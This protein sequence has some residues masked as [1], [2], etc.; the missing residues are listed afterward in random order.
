[1]RLAQTKPAS[2]CRRAFTLVEML[3]VIV[4]II[5]L[6][7]L[8]ATGYY[9]FIGGQQ[10]RNTEGNIRTINKIFQEQ[11]TFVVEQAKKET[12]SPATRT[13]ANFD[14]G[15]NN[16]DPTGERARV[17]WIK[18]R[19]VE[20]FPMTYDEIN[21][22]ADPVYLILSNYIPTAQRKNWQNY[23]RATGGQ[24]SS[25]K[26]T[27]SESSACLLMALSVSRGGSV[28]SP[29]QLAS[30]AI[31]TDGDGVKE[32]VD[33]WRTPLAFYRFAW[34][35]SPLLPNAP[36]GIQGLNPAAAGAKTAKLADPLDPS[37][38]LLTWP[39]SP[40]RVGFE[41]YLHRIATPSNNANANYVIP[42]IASAGLDQGLVLTAPTQ[43]A[44]LGLNMLPDVAGPPKLSAADNIYSFDLR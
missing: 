41:T 30:A 29:D 5:I 34:G 20:A 37:G 23:K 22:P 21:N 27:A 38:I 2:R 32:I 28:L 42:V 10:S 6:V 39:N 13:A 16:A 7:S 14:G 1:M 36:Q 8:T 11:W 3:V 25:A 15:S 19:L 40:Y 44:A 43:C 9:Y 24:L 26:T 17:L 31:D 18:L 4:I 33:G 12:P 35:S